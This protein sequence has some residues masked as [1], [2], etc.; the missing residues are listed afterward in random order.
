MPFVFSFSS[1][2]CEK[3]KNLFLKKCSL[4]N[5]IIK[6]L[7]IPEAFFLPDEHTHDFVVVSPFDSENSSNWVFSIVK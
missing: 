3:Q 6:E 4:S 7:N 2:K 1:F 5:V